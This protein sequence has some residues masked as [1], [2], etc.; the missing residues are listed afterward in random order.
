LLKL[1]WKIESVFTIAMIEKST[2]FIL[3]AGSSNP[4]G[5]PTATQLRTFIVNDFI[6][7]YIN[8]F[9]GGNM[10]ALSLDPALKIKSELIIEFAKSNTK[11]IDLFLARNKRYYE[12]GRGIISF[13]IAFHELK[14]KSR[15]QLSEE[16]RKHDWYFELFDRLTG[17]ISDPNNLESI[18]ENKIKFLTFNYDRSLDQFLFESLFYSFSSRRDIIRDLVLNF[19][20]NHVYGKLAMLDWEN[21]AFKFKYK[22][23]NLLAYSDELAGNI[24]IVYDNTD[25]N[26][27]AENEFY[28]E[29]ESIFFL[30]FGYAKENFEAIGLKNVLGKNHRVYGTALNYTDSERVMISAQIRRLNPGLLDHH[31][32]I[33]NLDS[34][35]LIREYLR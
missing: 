18:N 19:D 32:H 20:I 15:E 2:L 34:L 27:N 31:I 30:G 33:E 10:E 3:G 28:Q 21:A 25:N 24:N 26:L 4:Y 35:G 8:K 7:E 1:L 22:D 13:S 23:E 9:H 5:Y 6:T 11:S 14:S 17:D 29:F 16:E 12:G